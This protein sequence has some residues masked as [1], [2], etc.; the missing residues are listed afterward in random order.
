MGEA[1]V[2]AGTPQCGSEGQ[3]PYRNQHDRVHR[4]GKEGG[5]QVIPG[6]G[7]APEQAPA[8]DLE[9]VGE[10]ERATQAFTPGIGKP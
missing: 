5:A 10:G 2:D 6:S 7:P 9:R 1:A 8:K 3:K 4:Q